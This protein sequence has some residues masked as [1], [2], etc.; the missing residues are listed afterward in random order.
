[1][2]A[3]MIGTSKPLF[4]ASIVVALCGVATP[5]L[6]QETEASATAKF[7]K[8]FAA[9]DTNHDGYWSRAEVG[10]RIARMRVGKSKTDGAQVQKL[11]AM[12]FVTADTNHDGQVSEA[13]AEK[14]LR[15]TF[16]R[17]DANHDGKV[18]GAERAR[19]EADLR[20]R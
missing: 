15:A 6:A 1:M 10:A 4:I 17:Y 8:E 2:P 13:E 12:W 19:A 7:K 9:T 16:E 20:Q 11:A 5:S 18:G 3:R 14:L